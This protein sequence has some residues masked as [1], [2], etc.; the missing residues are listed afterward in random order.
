MLSVTLCTIFFQFSFHVA[1]VPE[2]RQTVGGIGIECISVGIRFAM[3]LHA[4]DLA[5]LVDE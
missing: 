2:E 1:G 3:A 5:T 4:H